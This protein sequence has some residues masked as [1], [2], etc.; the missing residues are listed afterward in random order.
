MFRDARFICLIEEGLRK[1]R[2]RLVHQFIVLERLSKVSWRSKVPQ[3]RNLRLQRW[4]T[5]GYQID[6]VLTTAFWLTFSETPP[7]LKLQKSHVLAYPS[8]GS[9][10][11]ASWPLDPSHKLSACNASISLPQTSFGCFKPGVTRMSGMFRVV[12]LGICIGRRR[13]QDDLCE[14]QQ[15]TKKSINLN[16]S[17]CRDSRKDLQSNVLMI[18]SSNYSW[19]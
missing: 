12:G 9:T 3:R 11:R 16:F 1:V 5:N 7:F 4:F 6:I 15:Q 18:I 13:F 14:E 19:F 2:K 8:D 10:Y 17:P